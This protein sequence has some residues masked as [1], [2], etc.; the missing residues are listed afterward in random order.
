MDDMNRQVIGMLRYAFHWVKSNLYD[1]VRIDIDDLCA[2]DICFVISDIV[3]IKMGM[4]MQ[5]VARLGDL[6]EPV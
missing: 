2:F 4:P 1:P 5:E 3:S 6:D